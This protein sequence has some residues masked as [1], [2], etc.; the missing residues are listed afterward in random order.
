MKTENIT[1]SMVS[2]IATTA[3]AISSRVVADSAPIK[4]VKLKHGLIAGIAVLGAAFLDRK[5]AVSAFTQDVAI[6]VSATQIGYL[7]KEL[8]TEPKGTLKTALGAPNNFLASYNSYDM[9]P[10]NEAPYEN[11]YEE[12]PSEIAFR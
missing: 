3:G 12:R 6:G 10:F 7:A 2:V 8:I 4:N 5:T 9:I 11:D 1:N